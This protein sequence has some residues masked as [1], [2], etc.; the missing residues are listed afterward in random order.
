MDNLFRHIVPPEEWHPTFK[1]L[2]MERNPWNECAIADW[3]MGFIQPP[4]LMAIDEFH[5]TAGL[6][7]SG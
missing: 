6:I 7:R 4:G 5:K 3:A 1:A 2:W